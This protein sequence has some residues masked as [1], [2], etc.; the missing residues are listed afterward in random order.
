MLGAAAAP[1]VEARPIGSRHDRRLWVLPTLVVALLLLVDRLPRFYQGDSIA[2]ISTGLNGWIPPDRSWVYGPAIRW[3][4]GVLHLSCA[5]VLLQAAFLLGSV[6]ML[7]RA[8]AAAGAGRTLV[9][10]LMI[11][12]LIDPL[13]EVYVRFWLTDAPAAAAFIGFVSS[14]ALLLRR[15]ARGGWLLLAVFLL[16]VVSSIFLRV[17]YVPV[18]IGT[19][20]LCLAAGRRD[21]GRGLRRRLIA[22]CLAPVVAVSLLAAAN[23]QVALPRLRGTPFVNAM[24]SL[25]TMG[26]LLPGLHRQDFARAGIQL[27]PIEFERLHLDRY[28]EREAQIWGDGPDRIRWLMQSRLGLTDVYD[29]ALQERARA[30]VLSALTHHP[31]SLLVVY[32]RSLVLYLEPSRWTRSLPDEMG[33]TRPLPGWVAGLLGNLSGTAIRPDITAERSLLPAMLAVVIGA[34]PV[35]TALGAA[36]ALMLL[37]RARRI[38]TIHVVAAALLASLLLAPL[39]SH[40][41]KPRYVLAT[42]TLSEALLTLYAARLSAD[43]SALRR[44]PAVDRFLGDVESA[45][46]IPGAAALLCVVAY[47]GQLALGRWQNDEFMLFTN[48]RSWGWH[49]LLP[50]LSYSPRPLSEAILAV[51]GEVVI[52]L[53]RPLVEPFLLLLWIGVLVAMTVAVRGVLPPQR[54]RAVSAAALAGCL[55]AFV[56]VTGNVTELFYWPMAAAAYLPTA[57]AASVLLFLLSGPLDARR[58]LACAAALAVAA[59]SSEMGAAFSISFGAAACLG[60]LS[61]MRPAIRARPQPIE[62]WWLLPALVGAGVLADILSMRAGMVELDAGTRALT[63]HPVTAATRGLSRMVLDLVSVDRADGNARP[64][65]AVVWRLFFAASFVALWRR[66]SGAVSVAGPWHGVLALALLGGGFFSTATAYYHYGSLCCERQQ[67]TRF[68]YVDLLTILAMAA[69]A[70]RFGTRTLASWRAPAWLPAAALAASLLPALFRTQGLLEDYDGLK[71]A[72]QAR[73]RTWRSAVKAE[74]SSVVFYLPPDGGHMLVRGT[75]EIPGTYA[76]DSTDR[77]LLQAIGRFFHKPEVVVCQPWQRAQSQIVDG[78]LVPPCPAPGPSP[79][80]PAP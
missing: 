77:P 7:G 9:L 75:F 28:D 56:L 15:P 67:S 34:Y 54:W 10:S 21:R 66:A 60:R 12:A 16:C 44:R 39:F 73:V 2:Y 50:R 6:L 3:L 26:V 40:M 45:I 35:M 41:V 64:S 20:M 4:T 62:L 57:A 13:N 68:W 48:E 30:V 32:L 46:F 38:E 18:E 78:Q 72:S 29:P 58:R 36:V 23:S 55:F 80:A 22:A 52:R 59:T 43:L 76:S 79:A 11:V 49:A 25:Y 17:A 14:L 42:V 63:G 70:G 53:Q 65:L 19:L 74:A 51:Y 61:W 27:S 33:S 31:G 1:L 37:L 5:V 47:V 8:A 24:S 71:L 69:L